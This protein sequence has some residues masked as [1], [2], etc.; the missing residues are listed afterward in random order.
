MTICNPQL[1]STI[2]TVAAPLELMEV[3][4]EPIIIEANSQERRQETVTNYLKAMDAYMATLP[5]ETEEAKHHSTN[6]NGL[7]TPLNL[8]SQ[9]KRVLPPHKNIEVGWSIEGRDWL[10]G[11]GFNNVGNTCYLNATLQALFHVP[12]LAQ[13]LISDTEHQGDCQ[14]NTHFLKSL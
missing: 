5:P 8:L 14:G 10:P 7:S 6:T 2:D 9:P 13:W 3:D 1:T 11:C 4:D 12:V